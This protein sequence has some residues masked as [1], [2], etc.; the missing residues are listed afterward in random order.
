MDPN[1]DYDISDEG[2]FFFSW[3]AWGTAWRVPAARVS[4]GLTDSQERGTRRGGCLF[5]GAGLRFVHVYRRWAPADV[6]KSL[7]PRQLD[8]LAH[9]VLELQ[10]LR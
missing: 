6:H 3:L 5:C 10:E 4:A 8:R 1:P 9:L 7:T 2:E